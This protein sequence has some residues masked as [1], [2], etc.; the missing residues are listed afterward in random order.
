MT[1]ELK[2]ACKRML[3]FSAFLI[4]QILNSVMVIPRIPPL[5]GIDSIFLIIASVLF[6]RYLEG[7]VAEGG[8]MKRMLIWISIM[9][10]LWFVLRFAKYKCFHEIEEIKRFCWYLY[11]IPMLSIPLLTF[12]SAVNIDT[13]QGKLSSRLHWMIAVTVL[14]ILL[15]LTND[16]HQLVFRFSA[17]FE[18]WDQRYTYG[19]SFFFIKAWE[20][21]LYISAIITM[22]VKCRVDFL[23]HHAWVVLLPFIICTPIILI[24]A[25]DIGF[26]VNGEGVLDVSTVLV[27]MVASFLDI[28]I[29]IGL[30]PSNRNYYEIFSI[31]SLSIQITDNTGKPLYASPSASKHAERWLKTE[32]PIIEE[33]TL[34]RRM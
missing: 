3:L 25:F 33:D 12:F 27:F 5:M 32:T 29:Q 13:R 34:I 24:I 22:I 17:H 14:L 28:S 18:T 11:Y 10:L 21:G 20:Y 31:S 26:K 2:T 4:V 16:S 15:V 1:G 7:C 19:I 8:L 23:K 30:I 9:M 6:M